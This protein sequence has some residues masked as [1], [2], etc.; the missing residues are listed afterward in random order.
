MVSAKR[1][2]SSDTGACVRSRRL[3]ICSAWASGAAHL[4]DRG[5]DRR[6]RLRIGSGRQRLELGQLGRVEAAR[7]DGV[8]VDPV[9]LEVPRLGQRRLQPDGLVDGHLLR[10]RH[11]HDAGLV[12]VGERRL[13]SPRLVGERPDPRDLGEVA[14]RLQEA[15]AV[16]GR[17]RVDDHEVVGA[18]R[19]GRL[20]LV[21]RELPDLADGHHLGEARR[22]R[23]EIAEEPAAVQK[24]AH[25]TDRQLDLEV[26][27]DCVVGVDRDRPQ[28]LAHLDLVEPDRRPAEHPRAALLRRDL[29]DDRAPAGG[30]GGEAEGVGDGRLADP[31]LPRHEGQPLVEGVGDRGILATARRVPVRRHAARSRMVWEETAGRD[32]IWPSRWACST[33][34]L[35]MGVTMGRTPP[36]RRT[37]SRRAPRRPRRRRGASTPSASPA[38]RPT[39]SSRIRP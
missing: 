24:L 13:D 17:R 39:R 36:R 23:R 22:R 37:T 9:D 21:Q 18:R 16:P 26:L 31:A 19:V 34:R 38:A 35:R 12:P 20:A 8:G 25:R 28:A 14:G 32:R 15:H 5:L 29:A 30:S 6:L 27:A 11:D 3:S 10:A 2:G 7:V 1:N 33:R 4:R